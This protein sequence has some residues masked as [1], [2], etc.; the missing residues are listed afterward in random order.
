M[1]GCKPVATPMDPNQKLQ[2]DDGQRLIDA[3]RYKRLVSH[4][5]YLSLT[6]PDIVVPVSVTSQFMDAPTIA[7]L[8]AVYKILKYLK[9]DPGKG[10]LFVNR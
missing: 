7:H 8:E 2:A 6:H 5:I 9:G 4:L 1:L 3:G 10:L